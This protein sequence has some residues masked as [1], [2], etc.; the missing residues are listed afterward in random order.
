MRQE[1][2][3]DLMEKKS[4]LMHRTIGQ[5]VGALCVR[6]KSKEN[7]IRIL[8]QTRKQWNKRHLTSSM[9]IEKRLNQT[10]K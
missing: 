9:L 1:T 5:I 7:V 10:S 6:Q 2:G 3:S 4:G 8:V